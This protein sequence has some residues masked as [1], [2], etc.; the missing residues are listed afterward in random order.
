M[1][2]SLLRFC[3]FAIRCIPSIYTRFVCEVGL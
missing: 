3:F 2:P 1:T